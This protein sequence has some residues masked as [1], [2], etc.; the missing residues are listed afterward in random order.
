MFSLEPF[1]AR[2]GKAGFGLQQQHPAEID[3]LDGYD[4]RPTV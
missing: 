4:V 2:P 1:M 3:V